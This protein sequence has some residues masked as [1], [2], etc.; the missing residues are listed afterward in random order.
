M[1]GRTGF[2][3][4]I[5]YVTGRGLGP[6]NERPGVIEEL[7]RT[8]G[9]E[10]PVGT[11][12]A[13]LQS[14]ALPVRTT[15]AIQKGVCAG[16]EPV[17]PPKAGGVIHA[18]RRYATALLGCEPSPTDPAHFISSFPCTYTVAIGTD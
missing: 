14:A 3:P 17:S 4:V 11:S 16:F 5:T 2:E 13:E 9:F 6:L 7:V 12:P 1:A 8:E 15:P 18:P 10:P